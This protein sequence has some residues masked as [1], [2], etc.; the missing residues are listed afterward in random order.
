MLAYVGAYHYCFSALLHVPSQDSITIIY[1][2]PPFSLYS[3]YVQLL[4]I[5]LELICVPKVVLKA[6]FISISILI[7]LSVSNLRGRNEMTALKFPYQPSTGW[8]AVP[9][10]CRERVAAGAHAWGC[11]FR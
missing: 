6:I 1:F 4:Q 2:T 5:R 3:T 7:T 8:S 9:E 10:K 11:G